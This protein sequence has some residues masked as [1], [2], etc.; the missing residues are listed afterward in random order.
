MICRQGD[1][2]PD[3]DA[4]AAKFAEQRVVL[5]QREE[6]L[7]SIEEPTPEIIERSKQTSC[8]R[9]PKSELRATGA[10]TGSL[11]AC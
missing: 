1:L 8:M 9:H 5:N 2:G 10:L 7:T 3:T 4:P 6:G 11:N